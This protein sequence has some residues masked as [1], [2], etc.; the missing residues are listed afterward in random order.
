MIRICAALC[1]AVLVTTS[2]HVQAR[3]ADEGNYMLGTQLILTS[4]SQVTPLN[5]GWWADQLPPDY[6]Y[7]I[8]NLVNAVNASRQARG[9]STMIDVKTYPI[10]VG[11]EIQVE[12]GW[13][14]NID[15]NR[16]TPEDVQAVL[17]AYPLSGKLA[18]T[19][20]SYRPM[21]YGYFYG[22]GDNGADAV[23]TWEG[24]S[25]SVSWGE[26]FDSVNS[27]ISAMVKRL[28]PDA[29]YDL[30]LNQFMPANGNKSLDVSVSIYLNGVTS[31]GPVM[32]DEGGM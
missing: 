8:I 15:F 14:Y 25:I 28:A 17:A 5:Q 9:I 4:A 26:S 2:F 7:G 12:G 13:E 3:A 6:S 22:H 29:T 20:I 30:S 31:P 27:K 19:K 18:D 24:E 23:L 16:M 1:A 21:S 32:Y 10:A 11:G